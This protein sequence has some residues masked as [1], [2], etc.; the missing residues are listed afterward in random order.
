[1]KEFAPPT[2]LE[3]WRCVMNALGRGPDALST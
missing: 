2:L 1:M 3:C